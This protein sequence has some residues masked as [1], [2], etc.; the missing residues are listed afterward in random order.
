MRTTPDENARM[1][2][3]IAAKLNRMEGEVRL[4]IPEGG[5][6][7]LDAPG[8]AFHDPLADQ[9]LFDTLAARVVQTER[10]RVIRLP[11]AVN[12]PPFAAALAAAFQS[13]AA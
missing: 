6:S 8:Q 1:A 5:V 3:W 2:E 9:A 13:I 12:D 7:A 11:Y 10:R 4:L